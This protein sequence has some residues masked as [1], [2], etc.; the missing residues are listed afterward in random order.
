VP[1]EQGIEHEPVTIPGA[2]Q[3][4]VWVGQALVDAANRQARAFLFGHLR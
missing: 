3:W 1:E 4:L 2:G